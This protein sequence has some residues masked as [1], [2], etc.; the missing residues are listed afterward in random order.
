MTEPK[1]LDDYQKTA[2]D[3]DENVVV[4]AGAG[5]GKT[6]VLAERYLRLVMERHLSVDQ[7]L[8]LTFTRKAASEMFSRIYQRL[9]AIDDV[10]VQQQV[11]R[12]DRARI[13]TID[14]FCSTIAR[15]ACDRY[16]VGANFSM[17]ESQLRRAAEETAIAALME[18]RR[19]DAIAWLVSSR[20]FETVVNDFF[21]DLAIHHIGIVHPPAYAVQAENQIAFLKNET[22]QLTDKING[23]IQDI[24]ALDTG[25]SK[26][27]TP[28]TI[29]S[30]L[31][32]LYPLEFSKDPDNEDSFH[33]LGRKAEIIASANSFKNI[34]S[35]V[36]DPVLVLLREPVKELKES[37]KKLI[38]V[39]QN[40]RFGD[41][42]KALGIVLD[43]F[44]QLFLARKR[45]EGI[46]SFQDTAEMAVDILK[47][48]HTVRNYYKN[49]IKAI[50]IDEFQDNNSLQRELLYLLSEK[51][52]VCCTG[53]PT[54]ADLAPD[55]LFFVGDEKQSI[56]RFRGADVSVFRN[57]SK[58]LH[59][60]I[61]LP[62]NYRSDPPLIDFFNALFPG[63]FANPTESYE[64]DFS[65]IEIPDH[66]R[67][68]DQE[69]KDG[70]KHTDNQVQ[71]EP[72]Q[73]AVLGQLVLSENRAPVEVSIY[74]TASDGEDGEADEADGGSG[75]QE[76]ED[77]ETI[78]L[79]SPVE[80][81]ALAVAHR[82]V[83]GI[84]RCEFSLGDVALLFRT[85][86]HQ[87]V[88]E[89]IFRHVGIPF[90]PADPRG[91]YSEGPANDIY[92]LLRLTLFPTDKNAYATVLRS[93]FVRLGDDAFA[94]I[95]LNFTGQPF[96]EEVPKTWFS[97]EE[98]LR[99]FEQG[100]KLYREVID[101]I[102]REPIASI[103]SFLWFPS[104]YRSFLLRDPDLTS[105]LEHFEYLYNLALEGDSRHYSMGTFLDFLA[106]L[107]G[108]YEKM[109]G[110]DVSVDPRRVNFLTIHK[111]KGLQFP[112]VILPS[113]GSKGN[114][115]KNGKPYYYD[116]EFGPVVNSRD[117]TAPRNA[118]SIN[119][120]YERCKESMDKQE[121]AELKRLFYVGATRAE[122]RLLLFGTYKIK[123][124][125][126]VTSDMEGL[127]FLKNLAKADD[128]ANSFLTLLS[129]G[130]QGVSEKSLPIR[131]HRIGPLN[132]KDRQRELQTLEQDL[133]TALRT[134]PHGVEELGGG[135][136]SSV[137]IKKLETFYAQRTP[138]V[139][140]HKK[141]TTSPSEM[142]QWFQNTRTAGSGV[143]LPSLSIDSLLSKADLDSAFGTLCHHAIDA[144][145]RGTAVDIPPSVGRIFQNAGLPV[146][147]R[148]SLL[149]EAVA[150]AKVFFSTPMG[151]S[152]L[153]ASHRRSEFPFLLPL[154]APDGST[155]MVQGV[156][157]A[158]FEDGNQTVIVDF[159]TDR[160][161]DPEAHRIQMECYR[162]AGAAFSDLP[163]K[164]YLVYLREPTPVPLESL[165]PSETETRVFLGNVAVASL[166][167]SP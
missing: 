103:I 148:Q 8:T 167:Q 130:L 159:K 17:N 152:L 52:T 12:F 166:S 111:S 117:E 31:K 137:A 14:A 108:T 94:W 93:P 13:S 72:D 119:Y 104:G 73:N 39:S 125:S 101:R 53:I 86:T 2:R 49:Q 82:I 7:I 55:K 107:M 96:P 147:D 64:A 40:L 85:T 99:R 153:R 67:F 28:D 98:D 144:T 46:L 109:E 155:V 45:Q 131:V 127:E 162:L 112:V 33:E 135:P 88:Y 78:T 63:V 136:P 36:K 71:E 143:A 114:S 69:L 68:P 4:S 30:V 38:Q 157:D 102:D 141:K 27:E 25:G 9:S 132:V 6:T 47:N 115:K 61:N 65:V 97:S 90:T 149:Q 43:R 22:A 154:P 50:M 156:M 1:E 140:F 58:D 92:A 145:I 24:L 37:A 133:L 26:S 89:R 77:T 42:I 124:D 165:K 11:R 29:K 151:E 35:N 161:R 139:V 75:N 54:I 79:V 123:K 60:H 138:S 62:T 120:L 21:V 150:L 164:T 121:L 134:G 91:L 83:E 80:R 44:A 66:R 16:G 70:R 84:R 5:S 126:P 128:T 19:D 81:E 74:C 48:D 122:H 15:G 32:G 110:G 56:Y 51:D 116:A 76:A 3:T 160:T 41:R 57:L 129:Q 18:H 158:I 87:N 142:E 106:P 34:G 23:I 95:M 100:R 105:N 20:N 59:R 113:I 118:K 163:V 10:G 146:S